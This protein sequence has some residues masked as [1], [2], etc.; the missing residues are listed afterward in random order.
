MSGYPIDI[1][2]FVYRPVSK[3]ISSWAGT[4][5][6]IAGKAKSR[7]FPLDLMVL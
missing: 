6:P 3:S 7:R 4:L 1:R 2:A 5:E